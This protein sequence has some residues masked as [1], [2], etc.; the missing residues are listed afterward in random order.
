M[1]SG[2]GHNGF[3]MDRGSRL[4]RPILIVTSWRQF[5]QPWTHWI[6]AARFPAK[7]IYG[8]YICR[9]PNPQTS[10]PTSSSFF[11]FLICT[12]SATTK[13]GKIG[14]TKVACSLYLVDHSSWRS[15]GLISLNIKCPRRNLRASIAHRHGLFFPL[16]QRK[17]SI[18]PLPIVKQNNP[19]LSDFLP[20]L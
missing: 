3:L 1:V 9:R 14:V 7:H 16:F 6:T 19:T 15:V 18:S 11:F 13:S 20:V 2:H 12:L 4:A 8:M 17:R 5:T 10:K